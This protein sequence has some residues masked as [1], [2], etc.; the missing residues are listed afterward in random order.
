MFIDRER[1]WDWRFLEL[2]KL[3]ASWSK[4]PSTRVGAVIVRPNR[5]VLSLGFN[6]FPRGC[7]DEEELYADR[8]QKYLRVVH[9]EM[10]AILTAAEPPR[11]CTLYVW[12]PAARPFTCAQCA[13]AVIQS[14]IIRVVGVEALAATFNERWKPSYAA[15]AEMYAE[16]GVTVTGFP[17][18]DW[19]QQLQ[20]ATGGRDI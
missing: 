18:E 19:L 10:N 6:G 12:P 16:A 11:H 15:A 17:A 13:A 4:D 9:G 8:D 2:A 5:T 3:V 1:K 14:G 20:E 7:S